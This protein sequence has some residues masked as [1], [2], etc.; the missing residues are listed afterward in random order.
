MRPIQTPF[1][2]QPPP[3]QH[4]YNTYEAKKKNNIF[5]TFIVYTLFLFWYLIY[6][7]AYKRSKRFSLLSHCASDVCVPRCSIFPYNMHVW[8]TV[9]VCALDYLRGVYI[10]EFAVLFG[11]RCVLRTRVVPCVHVYYKF[12]T[13]A[14]IQQNVVIIVII[15]YTPYIYTSKMLFTDRSTRAPCTE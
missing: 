1:V 3:T 2:T 12:Y 4:K 7:W 13:R 5:T 10:F 6:I 15:Q 9:C 14:Y 8:A 11:K